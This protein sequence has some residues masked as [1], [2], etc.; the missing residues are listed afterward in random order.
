MYCLSLREMCGASL[1]L[2]C[3]QPIYVDDDNSS[4]SMHD[5]LDDH[6]GSFDKQLHT[7]KRLESIGMGDLLREYGKKPHGEKK[8]TD[9]VGNEN[10]EIQGNSLQKHLF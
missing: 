6:C 9:I 5:I 8:E 10:W 7:W 3:N 4:C 1:L 2:V